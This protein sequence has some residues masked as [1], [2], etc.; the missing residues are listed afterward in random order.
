M[1]FAQHMKVMV[2]D[3][4]SVSRML[5]CDGLWSFG[6]KD[7]SIAADGE[8]ALKSMMATPCHL[9]I[10]DYNMPKMDGMQLLRALRE[11]T[12]TK[13]IGFILVTGRG[14]RELIEQGK[15]LGLNNYLP[16]PFT[17]ESLRRCIE[18]VVGKIV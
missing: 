4:T 8:A 13:N 12:P 1:P 6:I 11:Y 5:V 14:D 2:V 10:S 15:R 16:K 7:V 18:Q 17:N 9:V 3:D